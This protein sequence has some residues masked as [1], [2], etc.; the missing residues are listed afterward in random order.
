MSTIVQALGSLYQSIESLETLAEN[1]K[2]SLKMAR[3]RDL[4]GGA[5]KQAVDPV[6]VNKRLDALIG[7]VE[8]MLREG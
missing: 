8:L 5:G 3:Q 7:K 4:F 6:V 1:Q 2:M